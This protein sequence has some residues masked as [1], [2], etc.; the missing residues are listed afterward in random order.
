MINVQHYSFYDLEGTSRRSNIWIWMRHW[1][2]LKRIA[3]SSDV[4]GWAQLWGTIPPTAFSPLHLLCLQ[5]SYLHPEQ[6]I[7]YI[8]VMKQV[9]D[10]ITACR[11]DECR[12]WKII[13]YGFYRTPLE[14]ERNINALSWISEEYLSLF[15][16]YLQPIQMKRLDCGGSHF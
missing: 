6:F 2:T 1:G 3:P 9:I 10:V 11:C 4:N 8:V 7:R 15:I 16:D 14:E 12:Q 5:E 13:K